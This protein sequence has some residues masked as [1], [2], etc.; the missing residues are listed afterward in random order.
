MQI[1]GQTKLCRRCKRGG[2]NYILQKGASRRAKGGF[3]C[4]AKSK[5][6]PRCSIKMIKFPRWK[7]AF[8][9]LQ[10]LR[11]SWYSYRT[12]FKIYCLSDKKRNGHLKLMLLHF[13]QQLKLC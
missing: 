10:R 9:S 4:R 11:L 5:S 3:R 6:A 12:I 7:N 8:S 1:Y 13:E 2:S